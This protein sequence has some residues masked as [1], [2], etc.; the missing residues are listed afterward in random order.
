MLEAWAR[1][2]SLSLELPFGAQ[3]YRFELPVKKVTE[4]RR[5]LEAQ[6]TTQKITVVVAWPHSFW[7]GHVMDI[8]VVV[9]APWPIGQNGKS[10][11]QG[12]LT[13]ILNYHVPYGFRM[14]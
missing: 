8:I 13:C 12:P 11:N 14:F 2:A 10:H 1:W 5:D 9:S 7:K 6:S 3:A 4:L